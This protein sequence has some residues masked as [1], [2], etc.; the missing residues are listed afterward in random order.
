MSKKFLS[1]K[2][3]QVQCGNV[4]GSVRAKSAGAAFRRLLKKH[5]ANA[6]L[7]PLARFKGPD[8]P[9]FY[10]TPEALRASP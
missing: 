7:A 10:Q 3:W 5:A 1:V 4:R 6:A 2:N 9:W 8:T